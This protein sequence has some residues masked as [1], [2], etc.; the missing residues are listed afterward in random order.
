[1]LKML[2]IFF[3]AFIA[4]TNSNEKNKTCQCTDNETVESEFFNESIHETENGS[5]VHHEHDIHVASWNYDYVRK[6]LLI[7]IFIIIVSIIK[8]CKCFKVFTLHALQWH[9]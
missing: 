7:T 2:T 4:V 8:V 3:I 6:P 9:T 5:H 1:M